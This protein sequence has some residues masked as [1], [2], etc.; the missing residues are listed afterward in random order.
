VWTDAARYYAALDPASFKVPDQDGLPGW[1]E[2]RIAE[3]TDDALRLVAVQDT[4][5]VGIASAIFNPPSANARW[6]LIR[7]MERPWVEV[8]ALAVSE[9]HR[10]GGVG[11]ALMTAVEEWAALRGAALVRLET[12]HAS[13]LSVPFYERVGYARHG[14]VFHKPLPG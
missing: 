11:S 1:Y 4:E 10:R 6:Q 2:Q 14:L 9:R 12:Y 5:V 7:G 3:A 8:N 13:A